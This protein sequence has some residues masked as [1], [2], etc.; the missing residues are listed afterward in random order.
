MSPIGGG[1]RLRYVSLGLERSARFVSGATDSWHEAVDAFRRGDWQECIR[2][3]RRDVDRQPHALAPRALLT[4]LYLRTNHIN[5]AMHQ[6][7]RLLPIAIGNGDLLRA[8]A[9]QKRLDEMHT[10][11]S[12]QAR[13]YVALHQWFRA[14]ARSA[15][16]TSA[17]AAR[18]ALS[19]GALVGLPADVF[20]GA[21][22]ACALE[23]LGLDPRVI[24]ASAG[25]FWI[26]VYGSLRWHFEAADGTWT[27]QGIAA[28]RDVVLFPPSP[29][30]RV[31]LL[32]EQPAECL[33]FALDFAEALG[34]PTSSGQRTAGVAPAAEA[35][36]PPPG[37]LASPN[38]TARVGPHASRSTRKPLPPG[39][40]PRVDRRRELRLSVSP[41]NR[42]VLLLGSGSHASPLVGVIADLSPLGIGL[43]FQHGEIK[44]A[45][46]LE[47][48]DLVNAQIL[49]RGRRQPLQLSARVAWVGAVEG[50]SDITRVGLEFIGLLPPD[51]KRIREIL[52]EDAR[53]AQPPQ[54]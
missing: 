21:A 37:H 7:E 16:V 6:C 35:S 4:A 54:P 49:P 41:Q 13:R 32:P 9:A 33:A 43:R 44:S 31:R 5:L 15:P 25:M 23:S 1:P 3:V 8:L 27:E 47:P 19:N 46:G 40:E 50:E 28:E 2:M 17:S 48:G 38:G 12:V 29:G 45:Y 18:S 24:D 52:D 30:A 22:E 36:T 14:L 42:V 11:E 34:L 53:T 39:A 20:A 51:E 26:V 10:A